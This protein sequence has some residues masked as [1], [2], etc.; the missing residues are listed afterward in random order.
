MCEVSKAAGP[1]RTLACLLS[2]MVS[3]AAAL[4]LPHYS[5]DFPL[6]PNTRW[7]YHMHSEV[8]QGAHFNEEDAKLAKGNSLDTT[9]I[10][11][12]AGTDFIGTLKYTRVVSQRN[13]RIW[14]TEWD[15]LGPEGLMVGKTIDAEEGETTVM[16]PPQKI[17]SP[18]LKT[19]ESWDWKA[20]R[21]PV[22]MHVS[23]VGPDKVTVPA[24]TFD[25]VQVLHVL[26]V[27]S[28]AGTVV[29]RQTRWFAAGVGYVK[30]D[31]ESRLGSH[32]LSRNVMTLE[33]FEAGATP[34]GR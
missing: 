2:L 19:G 3:T 15:R 21:A 6:A 29:V 13:G 10:S 23:V 34:G 30:Q 32:L 5:P 25:A 12:V 27:N 28:Q 17:L 24:G 22:S 14:F 18:T 4:P 7:T 16:T 20:F 31:T 9:L 26:T 33:K 8:G 11:Q 1:V